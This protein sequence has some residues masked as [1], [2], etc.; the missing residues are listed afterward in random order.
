MTSDHD[1]DRKDDD[2]HTHVCLILCAGPPY[3]G[4]DIVGCGI[5][6]YTN[7]VFFTKNG[8]NLGIAFSSVDGLYQL[9]PTVSL[10][11]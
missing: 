10:H 4:G 11:R 2:D 5:N 6:F 9:Y 7:E 8:T 1:H 3:T